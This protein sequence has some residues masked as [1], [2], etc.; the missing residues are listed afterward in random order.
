MSNITF[1]KPTVSS[2]LDIWVARRLRETECPVEREELKKYQEQWG[3]P[4][5]EIRIRFKYHRDSPDHN[6]ETLCFVYLGGGEP[7]VGWA[8]CSKQDQFCK[9]TG[10]KVALARAVKPLD[11]A[12]RK[13]V[14]EAY[15]G[16]RSNEN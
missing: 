8:H 11:K 14:W 3:I 4:K 16:R 13:R 7:Y 9:E 5:D 15:F 6:G 10:R 2:P 12:T 1:A